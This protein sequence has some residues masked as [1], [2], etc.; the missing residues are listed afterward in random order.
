MSAKSPSFDTHILR[1]GFATAN[2]DTSFNHNLGR[3]PQA[4]FVVSPG[5]SATVIYKGSVAWTDT[6]INLRSS[7]ANSGVTVMLV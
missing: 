6:T 7:L 5:G 4:V 3:T 2:A 1:C